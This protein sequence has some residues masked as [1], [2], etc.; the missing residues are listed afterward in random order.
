[1]GVIGVHSSLPT[2][3]PG[4]FSFSALATAGGSSRIVC[5]C[6]CA[7]ELACSNALCPC[8][9]G[10]F[11][12]TGTC[13]FCTLSTFLGE[14]GS[15]SLSPS[16]CFSLTFCCCTT[17][18]CSKPLTALTQAPVPSSLLSISLASAWRTLALFAPVSQ[19]TTEP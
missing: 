11:T 7:L 10:G 19:S 14:R 17:T 13:F 8:I 6:S 16:S 3:G 12:G 18:Q 5:C 15:L 1:M 9:F 2:E 4:T